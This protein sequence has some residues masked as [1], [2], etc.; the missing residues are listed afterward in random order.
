MTSKNTILVCYI[1]LLP[2][3]CLKYSSIYL[4]TVIKFQIK[5]NSNIVNNTY[6]TVTHSKY[7]KIRQFLC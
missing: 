6:L 7:N 2:D 5:M 1:I 4:W 3:D